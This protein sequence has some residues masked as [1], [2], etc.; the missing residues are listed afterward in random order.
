MATIR[1]QCLFRSELPIVWLLCE[2]SDYS[3]VASIRRNTVL[4]QTSAYNRQ[5]GLNYIC[6]TVVCMIMSTHRWSL[7]VSWLVSGRSS[8]QFEQTLK[9]TSF[10]IDK[11]KKNMRTALKPKHNLW[12][13]TSL[14]Q[15]HTNKAVQMMKPH[16]SLLLQKIC[17]NSICLM[18]VDLW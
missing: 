5:S 13:A 15:T 11:S 14:T 3:R 1:G 9:V 7:L 8:P 17:G 18:K 12:P 6:D 2:G 16:L 4:L 10:F